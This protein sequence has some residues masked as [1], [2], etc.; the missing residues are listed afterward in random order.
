MAHGGLL[1]LLVAITRS[2]SLSGAVIQ[3]TDLDRAQDYLQQFGYLKE[4]TDPQDPQHLQEVTEALRM[5]QKV[6]DLQPSGELDEATLEVMSLPRCGLQDNFFNT[7][8]KFRLMGRWR[9]KHLTYRLHNY[10]PDM[11]RAQV[12]LSIQQAFNMWS[13]VSDLTFREVDHGL[14]EDI[15]I[16]FHDSHTSCPFPFDGLGGVLAHA[17]APESGRIHLDEDELWTEGTRRG[18]NLRIVAAHEIGHALGLGHSQ[19]RSALMAPV[20]VGYRG[21]FK[22]HSDD[23]NGI[24]ALYG[25]R[26]TGSPSWSPTTPADVPP[27]EGSNHS[28]A[29]PCT[30]RLD[31]IMLGPWKITFAFSGNDMWTITDLGHNPPTNINQL[32]KELP[33]NLN[34]AVHS[35][36]TNKTY[37]FKGNQVWRYSGSV[38]DYGYPKKVQRIPANIDAALYLENNK[39]LVFIKGSN[40]WQWDEL[41]YNI[42]AHFSRPL[43]RLFSGVP[44]SPDAAFTWTNGKVYFFRGDDY[45]RVN[46]RLTV[47][48]GYPLS[49][50][51]RWMRC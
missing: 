47:D 29:D 39:K 11:S 12:K 3:R 49:K 41:R 44:S 7:H 40:F 28:P 33:G 5:F 35:P 25:K 36:R 38:L 23:V 32:W 42:L 50:R 51:E 13:D 19:F 4:T 48:R 8:L 2:G 30:A 27:T 22:L 20:Y 21:N 10:T 26:T 24:Q 31:A 16:S 34:A 45:W 9:K 14:Q 46:K 18:S 15:R 1:V 6:N 37:F 17:E 43:A